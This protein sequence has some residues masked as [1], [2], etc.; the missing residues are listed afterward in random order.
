MLPVAAAM[1][2]P[3]TTPAVWAIASHPPTAPRW[4]A[5]TWSGTV[6]V[7]AASMALRAACASAQASTSDHTDWAAA[8]STIERTAPARPPRTQGS[9]RPIRAT[10]RSES[11]PHRG[12]STVDTAAPTP[13]TS[14]STASLWSGENFSACSASSTWIGPKKPAQMPML[15]RPSQTTHARETGR[16]GSSRASTGSTVLNASPVGLDRLGVPVERA[17]RRTPLGLVVDVHEAEPLRVALGPLEV[18]H[19]RPAV[20]A[21]DVDALVDRRGDR[22]QMPVEV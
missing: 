4:P 16:V 22:A 8:R 18:V 13:V 6:A 21:T 20:V 3:A 2:E 10:V 1:P 11:A 14:A 7:I 19:Q 12:L 17:L 9:R 15:I 5:G